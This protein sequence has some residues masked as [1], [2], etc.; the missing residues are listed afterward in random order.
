MLEVYPRD[1]LF[2]IST[3]SLAHTALG[4]LNIR[5]RR[6]V[7][8]FIRADVSGK[9]YSC[10][11][12]VPRDVFSTDL[13]QRIQNL[14][15]EELDAHFGDFNTYLSESVLARIQLILRFNGDAPSQFDLKRLESK[16]AR[17]A[18]SWRDELMAA[19]IEGFGE[20]RANHKMEQ[21]QDAFSASYREE[22]TARTAVFDVQHL[23]TLDEGD[24]LSLSL[25]RPL[26]EQGSGVNLKLYHRAAQIPLS[27]VLPMME[28]LGLRVI[29]EHPYQRPPSALL[30]P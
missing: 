6:Q 30:D 25:Y 18:R 5:E 21:F 9:F 24:D 7:R 16:V 3:D 22:F 28:N 23:L 2:Q 26:E 20:E 1:D 13:R 4:I 27:D 12:F 29:G 10:L 15:C 17:L 11:V 14:L 8:L 19:M